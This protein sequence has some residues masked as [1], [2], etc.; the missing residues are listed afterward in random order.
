MGAQLGLETREEREEAMLKVC[1]RT[2]YF[3]HPSSHLSHILLPLLTH[4]TSC[5]VLRIPSAFPT[6]Y[7]LLK[8]A[9]SG[10]AA[11]VVAMLRKGARVEARDKD[12]WSALMLASVGG[13]MQVVEILLA[14]GADANGSNGTRLSALMLAAASGFL[15]VVE[16]LGDRG[17]SV[18]AKDEDGLSAL[19]YA[20]IGGHWQVEEALRRRGAV[21]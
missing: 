13:H 20:S 2:S 18:E 17:A 19:A 15:H 14:N 16:A 4:P 6:S 1:T 7:C 12:G 5:S 11:G 8:A 21:E 3:L 10:N 9:G